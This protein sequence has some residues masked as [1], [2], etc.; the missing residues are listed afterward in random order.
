VVAL[1]WH[2]PSDAAASL[3]IATFWTAV[4][5][6]LLHGTGRRPAVRWSGLGIALVAVSAGLAAAAAL[7]TRHPQAVDAVRTSRASL[8]AAALFGAVS[9]A[10]FAC[11][12]VATG[13][14]STRAP[15]A[16][17]HGERRGAQHDE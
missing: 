7:A 15:R 17:Q 16:Q 3:F 10:L 6:A 5:S 11:C 2:Y 9:L 4:A 14:R 1:G 13:E 12:T 8:A